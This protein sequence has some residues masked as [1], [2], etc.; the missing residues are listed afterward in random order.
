MLAIKELREE[1]AAAKAY[2]ASSL[3]TLGARLDSAERAIE[4]ARDR[5]DSAQELDKAHESNI[6]TLI[7][8]TANLRQDHDILDSTVDKAKQ[9]FTERIAAEFVE[10]RTTINKRTLFAGGFIALATIVANVVERFF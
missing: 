2:Y 9:M 10:G 1:L 8:T 5:L 4:D 7:G 6:S 3:D